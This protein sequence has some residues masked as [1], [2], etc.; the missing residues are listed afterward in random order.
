MQP[1][2]TFV[3]ESQRRSDYYVIAVHS[4]ND[5]LADNRRSM[6]SLLARNQRTIHAHKINNAQRQQALKAI[7]DQQITA[8]IYRNQQLKSLGEPQARALCLARLAT[9]LDRADNGRLVI[10]HRQGQDER[11]AKTLRNF[12]RRPNSFRFD[13]RPQHQ[14]PML[15]A[16]DVIGWAY[17]KGGQWRQQVAHLVTLVDV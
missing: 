6:R 17:G 5:Q 11:D 1:V 9:D 7:V 16:A 15:W 13:H 3:D 10:E 12:R 8:T 4:P 14:E 2:T